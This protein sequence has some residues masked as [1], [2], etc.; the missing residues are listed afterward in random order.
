MLPPLTLFETTVNGCTFKPTIEQTSVYIR[1]T[2]RACLN[3]KLLL[4]TLE[5]ETLMEQK[6]QC[7]PKQ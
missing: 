3:G 1:Y 4:A 6:S 2:Q 7:V 5:K